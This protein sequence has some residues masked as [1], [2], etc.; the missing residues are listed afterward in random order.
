MQLV[1]PP[2]F[3][4]GLFFYGEKQAHKKIRL[5]RRVEKSATISLLIWQLFNGVEEQR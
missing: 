5:T 2:D 4:V 1:G 3:L